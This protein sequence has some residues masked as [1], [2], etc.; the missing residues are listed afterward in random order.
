MHKRE[1]PSAKSWMSAS[2]IAAQKSSRARKSKTVDVKGNQAA[3]YIDTHDY[4]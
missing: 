4:E 1:F 3:P 2:T